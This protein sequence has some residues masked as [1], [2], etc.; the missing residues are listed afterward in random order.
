MMVVKYNDYFDDTMDYFMET[1]PDDGCMHANSN[2]PCVIVECGHHNRILTLVL[3]VC[4][5]FNHF[6]ITNKLKQNTKW[7][8]FKRR[9]RL[10]VISEQSSQE[11]SPSETEWQ[12]VIDT[13]TKQGN[14]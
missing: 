1:L 7:K 4:N 8:E 9:I 6:F 13:Q 5:S 11:S 14:F 12:S 3:R 10:C 2:Y